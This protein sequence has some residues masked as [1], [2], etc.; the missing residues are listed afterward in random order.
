MIMACVAPL[1]SSSTS[2][3]SPILALS[4]P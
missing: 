1:L 4:G 2:Q 3:T